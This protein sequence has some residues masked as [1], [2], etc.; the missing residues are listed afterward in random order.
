[1]DNMLLTVHAVAKIL[2]CHP[3]TVYRLVK[4]GR[5]SHRRIGNLIRFSNSDVESYLNSA[6]VKTGGKNED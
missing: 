1:M 3:V 2:C 5:I 4:K 6:S